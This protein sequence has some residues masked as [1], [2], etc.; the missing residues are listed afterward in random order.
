MEEWLRHQLKS[1]ALAG[2]LGHSRIFQYL[3]AAAP[4]VTELVTIGK[5]WDLAQLERR[6][7]RLGLRRRDRGR[8]RDRPR[9]G[10][11]A[12]AAHLRGDRARGADRTARR[13]HIDGFLRDPAAPAVVAVALPEEMPVNETI[14]LER[15]AGRGDRAG[16]DAI[17]VNAV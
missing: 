11:A 17:V 5:V 10:A 12:R 6:T 7:R 15:A 14:D 8:A 16:L 2:V 3:T 1:G 9:P 4:G 13:R